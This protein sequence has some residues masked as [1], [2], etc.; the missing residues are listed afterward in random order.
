[1]R[2]K[3]EVEKEIEEVSNQIRKLLSNIIEVEQ[4]ANRP[5]KINMKVVSQVLK[6]EE[7]HIDLF[8]EYA[9]YFNQS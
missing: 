3:E 8:Q 9:K 2:T 7:R 5:G 4:T 1:M 6:L